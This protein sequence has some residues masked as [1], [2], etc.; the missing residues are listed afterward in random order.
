M[1]K[2]YLAALMAATMTLG[3]ASTSLAASITVTNA[4]KD[5]TYDVYKI[6]D[7]TNSGDNYAYSIIKDSQWESLVDKYVYNGTEVFTLTP[8]ANDPNKLVVMV[9]ESF[10]GD[11]AG[12]DFAAYLAANLDGKIADATQIPDA[13]KA[14]TFEGLADGYYFVDTSLGSL[15]ALDT[16]TDT[17]NVTDKNSD[18][19]IEKKVEEDSKEAGQDAWGESN[20][21][22]IGQTVNFKTTITAYPGA[23]NFVLHDEME[24]GL[25]LKADTITV[26]GLTKEKDYTVVTTDLPK[27]GDA[28]FCGFADG[29][30][31]HIEFAE[32][33]LDSLTEKTDIVVTYSAIL[34]EDAEIADETNDNNTKLT[35]G[36]KS[37]TEWDTTETTT[38]KF[39]IIKTD[40]DKKLLAGA[41]FELYDAKIAGNKIDLVK[42]GDV[43]RRATEEEKAEEGFKSVIIEA[44]KVTVV[45]LD[46][47][48]NYYLEETHAPD[49][50]NMLTERVKV[51]MKDGNLTTTMEGDTWAD[52]NGGVQITNE[53]GALLPSTGGIGTTIFYILGGLL[54]AFSGVVLFAKKRMNSEF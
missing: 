8:S 43:Y 46:A 49:G 28:D 40:E 32:A 41:E 15:C 39:D 31:F 24:A 11:A 4:Q 35:Y 37:K 51:E 50:Y 17:V 33:Y 42:D 36:E 25:T 26:E 6:F 29:C 21:A 12:A 34:N 3:M 53:T 54:V 7:V 52:D 13:D 20:T 47:N 27:V 23:E 19:T 10:T 48:T 38:L 9:D 44:G 30:D 1:K 18:P 22:H 5:E 14:I 2:R 45:G 16:S